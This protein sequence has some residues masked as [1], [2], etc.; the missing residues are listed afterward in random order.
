MRGRKLLFLLSTTVSAFIFHV[1]CTATNGDPIPPEVYDADPLDAGGNPGDPE[2]GPGKDG[3]TKDVAS[4]TDAPSDAPKDS[5]TTPALVVINEIYVDTILDG[6]AAEF[7]EL[8]ADPGSAVDD[9]KLRIIYPNGKV[10]YEVAV[11]NAGDKV[12]AT[13]L[14]VV[15]GNRLDK[16]NVTSRVDRQLS[17]ASW[18]LDYPGAVQLVRGTTLLD[19]VG[20]SDTPDAGGVPADPSLSPPTATVETKAATIP[21]NSGAGT[22]TKRKSFG[23]KAGAADSN[24]NSKDFCTM[25]AS[26]GF[27]QKACQ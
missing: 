24:D 25:E 17:I 3:A 12:G 22:T 7:V 16:L 21:D 10:K 23:R 14:W 8:R 13:G 20:F 5:P 26:P 4:T 15:G 27:A 6:D 19:V 18:G 9:L 1:A 11:G 2:G